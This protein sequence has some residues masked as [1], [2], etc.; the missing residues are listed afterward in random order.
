MEDYLACWLDEE[1][2]EGAL[3]QYHRALKPNSAHRGTKAVWGNWFGLR[4]D[5]DNE[6]VTFTEMDD[7]EPGVTMSLQEARTVIKEAQDKVFG[8]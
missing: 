2:S 6:L 4:I 7:D 1:T 8:R 3:T 5:Y